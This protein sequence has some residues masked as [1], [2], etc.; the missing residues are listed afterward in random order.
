LS[1]IVSLGDNPKA[2]ATNPHSQEDFAEPDKMRIDFG[3]YSAG[4]RQ[5]TARAIFYD[6]VAD[7]AADKNPWLNVT[8]KAWQSYEPY[9]R[10]LQWSRV[11]HCCGLMEFAQRPYSAETAANLITAAARRSQLSRR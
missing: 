7:N 5:K 6:G 11:Y 2:S 9:S 10:S 3:D 8:L 4:T 1:D